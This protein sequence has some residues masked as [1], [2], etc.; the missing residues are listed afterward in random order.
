MVLILERNPTQSSPAVP[1]HHPYQENQPSFDRCVSKFVWTQAG[2]GEQFTKPSNLR[3]IQKC[4]S[5]SPP[6][7]PRSTG[8]THSS[9]TGSSAE[10]PRRPSPKNTA[11]PRSSP[12]A[13]P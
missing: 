8:P 7:L 1:S 11:G 13:T 3:K 5:P 12:A 9:A 6:R 2:P 10:C 4:S